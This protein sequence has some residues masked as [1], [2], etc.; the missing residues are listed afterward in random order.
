VQAPG[1]AKWA[2]WKLGTTSTSDTFDP[3]DPLYTAAGTYEFKARLHTPAG[4]SSWS[5]ATSISIG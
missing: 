3:S 4:T 1:S 5:S 2:Y